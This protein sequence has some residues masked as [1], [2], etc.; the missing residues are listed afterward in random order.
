MSREE[1]TL[2]L[3][4]KS[5]TLHADAIREGLRQLRILRKNTLFPQEIEWEINL[6]E[7]ILASTDPEACAKAYLGARTNMP[8]PS[9]RQVAKDLGWDIPEPPRYVAPNE[10]YW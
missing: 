2:T 3:D 10:R 5:P 9:K 8:K 1:F 6:Y 7:F 4:L